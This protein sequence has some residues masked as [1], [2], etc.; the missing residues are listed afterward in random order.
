MATLPSVPPPPEVPMPASIGNARMESDGTL[1]LMLRGIG[2]DGSIAEAL[3]IL[4]PGEERY[5]EMMKILGPMAP[6]D[7]RLIPAT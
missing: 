6:G 1:R 5:A 3:A 4:S 2:A 7:S